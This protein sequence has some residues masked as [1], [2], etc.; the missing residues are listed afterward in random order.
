LNGSL[1]N[2]TSIKAWINP[3]WKRLTSHRDGGFLHGC[4]ERLI[5]VSIIPTCRFD[6]NLIDGLKRLFI[7]SCLTRRTD[8]QNLSSSPDFHVVGDIRSDRTDLL[9]SPGER[10]AADDR[11]AAV[12]LPNADPVHGLNGPLVEAWGEVRSCRKTDVLRQSLPSVGPLSGA[13]VKTVRN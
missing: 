10:H 8:P 9:R 5:M 1:Q 6:F 7:S 11:I 12:P 3:A 13:L 2:L 4:R